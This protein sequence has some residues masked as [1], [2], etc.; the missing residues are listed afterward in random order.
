MHSRNLPSLQTLFLRGLREPVRLR[1]VDFWNSR[2]LEVV[3]VRDCWV[4]GLSVPP[5]CNVFVSA[6]SGFIISHLDGFRG[7]PLVS[8]AHHVCLPTDLGDNIEV[9]NYYTKSDEESLRLRQKYALGIP[10]MFPAMR[11]LRMTWPSESTRAVV[12]AI[13]VAS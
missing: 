6:Q 12:T 2:T 7:H 11:S 3:N 1:G 5:F 10:N 9:D 4:D 8:R 13:Q